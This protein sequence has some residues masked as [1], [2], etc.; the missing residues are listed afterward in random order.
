MARERPTFWLIAG[1]NGVGK[2]TYAMRHLKAVSGSINFVNLDEIA[3]GL[4]PLEPSAA[5]T[6]AARIALS[7]ART[8]IRER[9]TFAMETT[10]A[11]RSHLHLLGAA[12]ASGLSTAMLYFSVRDPAIC[13]ERIARRVAEGGHDVPEEVVRR[14]FA[15]SLSNVRRYAEVCDLWRIY[16]ASG[17]RPAL[18]LE[19]GNQGIRFRDDAVLA[20][21][22]AGLAPL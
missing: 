7:R 12:R 19:G 4:S 20:S 11:G 18:A 8:F 15:R 21:G 22:H 6:E 17:P 1:P 2:T 16:E 14:R 13:L 3:R 9:S 5:Q 10:L